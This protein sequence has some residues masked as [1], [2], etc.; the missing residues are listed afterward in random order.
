MAELY[1]ILSTEPTVEVIPPNKVRPLRLVTARSKPSGIVYFFAVRPPDFVASHVNLI[2]HD[3][4]L[5]MEKLADRPG[6][7]DVTVE[8]SV[9]P[10][11]TLSQ[12]VVV[13]V[14]STSGDSSGDVTLTWG[15]AF[16]ADGYK[17]VAALRAELDKIEGL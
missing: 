11:D 1:T 15:E 9:N 13:T 10:T 5:Y 2:A 4:A 14:E 6:V 17:K 16:G 8:Q 7:I 3:I 12:K